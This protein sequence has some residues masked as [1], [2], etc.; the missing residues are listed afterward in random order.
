VP[1]R[2]N[3]GT[4]ICRILEAI[5]TSFQSRWQNAASRT[6]SSSPA[7]AERFFFI[8]SPEVHPVAQVRYQSSKSDAGAGRWTGPRTWTRL[9]RTGLG[10]LDSLDLTCS[11]RLAGLVSLGLFRRACFVGL[12]Q[13]GKKERQ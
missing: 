7:F 3:A 6:I 2:A 9:R 5:R 11:T 10:G 1:S 4:N 13:A 12:G 8:L